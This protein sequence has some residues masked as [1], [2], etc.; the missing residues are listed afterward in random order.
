M[1]RINPV[2][3]DNANGKAKQILDGLQKSMGMTP[4]IMRTLA[5]SPAALEAY[6][7]LLNSLNGASI[8]GKTREA[9]A[10]V[11]SGINGCEYCAAAHTAIGKMQGLSDAETQTSL[12]G[13]SSEPARAS[14]LQFAS[15]IVNKRGWV[16]DEDLANVRGAGFGDAE[17]TDIVATV[18]ATIFSNYFNHIAQTEVDFPVVN[19]GDVQAA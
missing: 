16:S 14:A 3:P 2:N 19:M 11:T 15:A 10:L 5:N 1:P 13:H 7:G 8:D 17:I 4:N 12:Q 9:I 18:A 6:T